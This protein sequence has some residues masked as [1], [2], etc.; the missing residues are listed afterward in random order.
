[1]K[2]FLLVDDHHV[3]RSGLKGLLIE[4]FSQ[5][6]VYEASTQEDAVEKLKQHQFELVIMDIQIPGS[7]ML[8]LM[9]FIHIKYPDTRVLV[10]SMSLEQIYATRFLKAGAKGFVSKDSSFEEVKKAIALILNDRRYI[11]DTLAQILADETAAD[12]KP[13][14]FNKLS[15]REFE[16]I[17]LLLAGQTV[18]DIGNALNLHTSSVGTFKMRIFKKLKVNNILELNEMARSYNFIKKA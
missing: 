1:M 5:P 4:L 7:D 6:E 11:S 16:I 17:N 12:G 15:I 13:N 8:A 3:V 9:E 18:T 10:F 2:K 14:P